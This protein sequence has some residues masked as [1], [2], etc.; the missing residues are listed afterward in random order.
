M[1][2][3]IER[4]QCGVVLI[5]VL[6]SVKWQKE[7]LNV[8]QLQE[9]TIKSTQTLAAFSVLFWLTVYTWTVWLSLTAFIRWL[10]QKSVMLHH[11][12]EMDQTNGCW[13]KSN[14]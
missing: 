6:S 13:R 8:L 5:T 10:L 12:K 3:I 14:I 1:L 9:I 11:G 7:A 4:V 2:F